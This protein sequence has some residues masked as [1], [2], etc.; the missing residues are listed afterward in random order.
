MLL[1]DH[2]LKKKII[3]IQIVT[4]EPRGNHK[5][6]ICNRC[7]H[8]GKGSFCCGAVET[9]LTSNHE[10]GGSIPG[11]A[12]WVKV[13]PGC[14]LWCRSQMQLRSCIAVAVVY[15]SSCSSDFDP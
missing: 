8:K 10:V 5:P 3:H 6:K 9:N 2:Q 14:E 1:R 12:Q 11:L 15:T 13:W 7:A 4:Y